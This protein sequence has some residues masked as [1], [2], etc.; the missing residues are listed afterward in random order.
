MSL[1]IVLPECSDDKI[2]EDLRYLTDVLRKLG[3]DTSEGLLG[4]TNGYGAYFENDVFM[5][6]PYCWCEQDDCPWCVGCTCH[7]V[8]IYYVDGKEVD[9][10]TWINAPAARRTDKLISES[11]CAYC[12]DE[13]KRAPN[14]LHK[15]SGTTISWYKYIGRGMDINL[16]GN[17]DLNEHGDWVTIFND[18]LESLK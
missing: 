2:S 13:I 5:M 3:A 14:F 18:C 11:R 12:R 1:T 16:Y 9:F 8:Y 4:G 7:D 6:H 10:R 15:P 17:A